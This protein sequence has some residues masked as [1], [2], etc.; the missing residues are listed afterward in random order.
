MSRCT[1]GLVAA[2]NCDIGENSKRLNFYQ[3]ANCGKF[4]GSGSWRC[5]VLFGRTMVFTRKRFLEA[6]VAPDDIRSPDDLQRIPLLTKA[7]VRSN[8]PEMISRG[9][10][11]NMLQKAKTGGSTGRALEL[12]FTE[13][14][15]SLRNACTLR[16]DLWAGWKRGE[17][18]A[19]IW[20]NPVYPATIKERIRLF[21]ALPPLIYLDTMAVSSASVVKFV[22]EWRR[23]KPTLIFGHSHSIFLL[24]KVIEEMD[25]RD[26]RP[27]RNY[28]LLYDA[29]L[30]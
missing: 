3:R 8:A 6:G 5:Y 26:L 7:E 18:V 15:S 17:P 2:Q 14:C 11:V 24:A 1:V 20:G 10:D 13:E 25:V 16:H 9:F 19:A 29:S 21:F 4:S 30:Q 23:I 22:E 27:Q 28:F 12:Y